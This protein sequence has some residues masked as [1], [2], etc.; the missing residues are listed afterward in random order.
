MEKNL[1]K[2]I[3]IVLVVIALISCVACGSSDKPQT[4]NV[5]YS[6]AEQS[7]ESRVSRIIDDYVVEEFGIEFT[8]TVTD[9]QAYLFNGQRTEIY[10]FIISIE[11]SEYMRNHFGEEFV[12][13]NFIDGK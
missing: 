11:D 12:D 2:V 13:K 1:K 6:K 8:Y 10:L 9:F 5:G 4:F 3:A 7:V